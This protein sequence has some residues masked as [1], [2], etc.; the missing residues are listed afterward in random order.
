[1]IKKQIFTLA[2][3]VALAAC[4]TGAASAQTAG[5][6]DY[7]TS[8]EYRSYTKSYNWTPDARTNFDSTVQS[9]SNDL[10]PIF[11]QGRTDLWPIFTPQQRALYDSYQTPNHYYGLGL[12]NSDQ[13]LQY[14]TNLA[15]RLNL[16][17][18]QLSRYQTVQ[19]RIWSSVT[20]VQQS[21]VTRYST[22]V[23]PGDWENYRTQVTGPYFA[24]G[25]GQEQSGSEVMERHIRVETTTTVPV[26]P[27]QDGT[28]L[29]RTRVQAVPASNW[30]NQDR[31]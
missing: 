21:Y 25:N 8:T 31:K 13:Y 27:M 16:T 17:P 3:A 14:Q 28:P 30:R 4:L 18:D 10:Y 24:N 26:A 11:W 23:A 5:P 29:T 9:Q 7:S 20:P 2:A 22:N 1:M 15:Q 19:N 12:M 6:Y